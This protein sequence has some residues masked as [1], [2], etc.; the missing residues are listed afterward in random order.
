MKSYLHRC[1]DDELDELLQALPAVALEGPKAVGKTETALR[2]A[3]T[4][5]RL[6]DPGQRA[7]AEADP[8][9]LVHGDRP[10]LFDEWQRVPE[11]WD[12]VR[13]AVDEDATPG[14]FLLTGSA[15][16]TTSP[17]HSGAG[18]IVTLRMRPLSLTERGGDSPAISLRSL[19][20]G[21]HPDIGGTTEFSLADYATEIVASGLPGLRDLSG[22]ALR[23]QL[24]GYLSRIVDS[25]FEELGHRVRKPQTLRRWMAAYAAATATTATFE[26]IRAAATGGEGDKPAKTTTLP[27]RDVLERLWIV[28]EVPAWLPTRSHIS[29]LS[30]PPKHH[31]ADPALAARLLGVGEDALLEG[32]E[33]SPRVP[34]D[35]TLLGHLFESLVTLGVRT[36]A[37]AAEAR[38]RHLRTKDG[39]Q[40]VDLIV[41]RADQRIV[42]IEVKLNRTVKDDDTRALLWLKERLGEDLLDAVIVNTGPDAYRRKDGIAVVPATL[43]GP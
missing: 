38:V 23:A 4:V 17:T 41:E 13:R 27:Y 10:I 15:A 24:N 40:E 36:Y 32:R 18:R 7:L 29:R 26:T 5:H 19:L 35:G 8:G 22:R 39:R 1:V 28:E 11:V 25:D 30:Q 3:K 43:L 16:P 20:E 34:R 2:R 9:R 37:Q 33:P 31:L 6:D 14:Q 21:Q 12:I 42:A